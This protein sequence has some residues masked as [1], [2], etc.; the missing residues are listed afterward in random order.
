MAQNALV[1]ARIDEDVKRKAEAILATIGLTTSDALRL[2]LHRVV[3]EKRLPFEPLVPNAE[4]IKAIEDARAGRVARVAKVA[5]IFK[6][7]KR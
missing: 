1:R 5:D 6:H 3:A 7:A 2:L 4:T